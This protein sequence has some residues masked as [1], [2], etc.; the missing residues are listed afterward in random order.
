MELLINL[1]GKPGELIYF[2]L[3]FLP[4]IIKWGVMIL[5][6][7][8]I[9]FLTVLSFTAKI[10][11][12]F[13]SILSFLVLQSWWGYFSKEVFIFDLS[14]TSFNIWVN[15]IP[16]RMDLYFKNEKWGAVLLFGAILFVIGYLIAHYLDKRSKLIQPFENEKYLYGGPMKKCIWIES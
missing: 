9:T 12:L 6:T 3:D 13:F 10:K 16:T 14:W 8:L 4:E 2:L 11:R 7:V 5:A 1:I 15:D